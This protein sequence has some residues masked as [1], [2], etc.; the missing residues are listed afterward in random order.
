MGFV[1][2]QQAV[3]FHPPG[4]VVGTVATTVATSSNGNGKT[5]SRRRYAWKM[6]EIFM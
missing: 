4:L 2:A 6:Q 3:Y 1:D 5:A